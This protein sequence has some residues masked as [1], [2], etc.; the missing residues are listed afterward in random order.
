[1]LWSHVLGGMERG[2]E[3]QG[4]EHQEHGSKER[5]RARGRQERVTPPWCCGVTLVLATAALSGHGDL[6]YEGEELT[7]GKLLDAASGAALPLEAEVNL[8]SVEA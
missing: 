4:I 6:I 2:T 3:F 5:R 1:M 7:V 8:N